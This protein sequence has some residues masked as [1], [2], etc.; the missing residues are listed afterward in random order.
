ML[1]PL[2][3]IFIDPFS[4]DFDAVSESDIRAFAQYWELSGALGPVDI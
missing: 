4:L 3:E 1:K 2:T